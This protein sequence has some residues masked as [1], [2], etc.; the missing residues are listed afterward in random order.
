MCIIQYFLSVI[1]LNKR[2]S[3]ETLVGVV[4]QTSD[5]RD[6]RRPCYQLSHTTYLIFTLSNILCSLNLQV[7]YLPTLSLTY[8]DINPYTSFKV[9]KGQANPLPSLGCSPKQI[10][11]FINIALPQILHLSIKSVQGIGECK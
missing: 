1:N 6:C 9:N 2:R 8:K 11:I 5:L 7:S 3:N 4:I 10:S